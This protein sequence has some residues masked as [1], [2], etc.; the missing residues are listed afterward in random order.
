MIRLRDILQELDIGDKLWADEELKTVPYVIS[1]GFRAFIKR[2]YE[3]NWEPNTD[4]E[5]EILTQLMRYYHAEGSADMNGSSLGKVFSELLPLK[6]K[7]PEI[8]DPTKYSKLKSA[9]TIDSSIPKAYAKHVWRGATTRQ[10]SLK[11]LL[12]N[13]TWEMS[14]E[15]PGYIRI[16]RPNIKYTSRNNFG[17]SSFSFDIKTALDFKG[18]FDREYISTIYGIEVNNPKLLINPDVKLSPYAEHETFYIGKSIKP[19]VIFI[20]DDRLRAKI[21]FDFL[22]YNEQ[23][24]IYPQS[25]EAATML[26]T[27]YD[28]IWKH[29]PNIRLDDYPADGWVEA[30]DLPSKY[31][32]KDSVRIG[33]ILFNM[34]H[35]E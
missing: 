13:S 20:S 24:G 6:S 22:A 16:D 3:P 17:F 25:W 19:D 5:N 21:Y 4:D 27:Y 35:G 32:E 12:P 18:R 26:K 1:P 15:M 30:P 9:G 14:N 34:W 2:L 28:D 29:A 11:S 7:F 33:T 31:S 10:S 23:N 8:L